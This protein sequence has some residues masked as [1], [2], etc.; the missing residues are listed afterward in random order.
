MI[1]YCGINCLECEIYKAT[2]SGEK[3]YK[4]DLR[5]RAGVICRVLRGGTLS[6]GDEARLP[7]DP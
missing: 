2:L 1:A 4:E 5:R 7:R 3:E 6:V